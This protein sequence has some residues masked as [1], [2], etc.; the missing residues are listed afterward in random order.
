MT[1]RPETYPKSMGAC[2]DLL[3]KY[4]TERL[5]A[6]KV[7]ADLKAR[8]TALSDYIIA[9]LPKGD[10]GAVGKMYRV[11]VVT[12]EI[13]QVKDWDAFWAYVNKKKANFLLQKRL[14]TTAVKEVLEN[15]PRGG[16]PGLGTFTA[17][18]LSLKR[19]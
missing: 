19:K 18:K 17:V 16:I 8:E 9:N 5:A 2:A 12:E 7:A 14:S 1:R 13:P 6:D 3:H 10:E 11:T 15:N 4:R